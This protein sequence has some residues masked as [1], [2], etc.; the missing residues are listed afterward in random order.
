MPDN[1]LGRPTKYIPEVIFPQINEYLNSVNT[2]ELPSVDGLAI[3]LN[4][5][6]STI[7]EW[8]KEYPDF[9]V[10]LKKIASKQRTQLMNDGMYGGKEVNA[11]MAIFLLKAI[12]GLKDGD[13]TTNIQVNVQPILGKLEAE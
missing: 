2:T 8:A 12:H 9:S 7:Y 5:T 11:S 13:G 10:Y 6:D 3:Y 1:K 4:V